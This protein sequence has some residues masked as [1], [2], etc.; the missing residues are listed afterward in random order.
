MAML[1]LMSKSSDKEK[2]KALFR[3]YD[4]SK[5]DGLDREEMTVMWHNVFESVMAYSQS[6]V[7]DGLNL[8]SKNLYLSP[9]V[10]L[11]RKETATQEA[12]KVKDN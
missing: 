1:F 11:K 7:Q 9:I 10:D 2:A 4:T 6:L 12:K 3:L 5:N 8:S